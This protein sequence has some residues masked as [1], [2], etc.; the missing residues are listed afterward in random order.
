SI[1]KIEKNADDI[2]ELVDLIRELVYLIN[3][4]LAYP[5]TVTKGENVFTQATKD[6]EITVPTPP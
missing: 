5:N 2:L 3:L 6:L 4:V 1:K